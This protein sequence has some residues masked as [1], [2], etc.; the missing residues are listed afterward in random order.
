[1]TMISEY[2]NNFWDARNKLWNAI[3]DDAQREQFIS[4]GI[5]EKDCELLNKLVITRTFGIAAFY[6]LLKIKPEL[7]IDTLFSCYLSIDISRSAK[8]LAGDLDIMFDD[9]KEVLGED[10]L[11]EILNSPEFLPKNKRNPRV[12]EAIAFALDEE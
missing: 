3:K 5:N 7:A 2:L 11:Q 8:N 10:K 6:I 4:N 9:I 12:K 1:M